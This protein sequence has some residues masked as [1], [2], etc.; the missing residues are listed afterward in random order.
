MR[1]NMKIKRFLPNSVTMLGLAFGVSSLN[2]AYWEQWQ[3]A[4]LFILLAGLCDFL[5]GK[6]ARVL[7]VSSRFGMELDTLS[8][9]VSF[10]VAPAFLMYQWTLDPETKIEVMKHVTQRVDAIGIGW[11]VVLFMVMCCAMRLA[12]FNV[13]ADKKM[14]SYWDHYFMGV[15]AP[16]GAMLATFP[17]T[18]SLAMHEQCA[19]FRHPGFGAAFLVFAGL[20]MIS[21]IP[22]FSLKHVKLSPKMFQLVRIVMLALIAGILCMPWW[23]MSFACL[24]YMVSIPVSYGCFLK[25]KKKCADPVEEEMEN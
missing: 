14:P 21:R 25:A 22:T 12:R 16:A 3:Q 20:V 7:R 8:D 5:D 11:G 24:A 23:V 18:L 6:V 19:L 2:M 13:M 10:G 1:D 15:P 9:F 4:L 17:L